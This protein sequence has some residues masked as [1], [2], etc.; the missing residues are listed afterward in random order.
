MVAMIRV[1]GWLVVAI[2]A[3]GVPLPATGALALPLVASTG[4]VVTDAGMMA[5]TD[6]E[7][8]VWVAGGQSAFDPAARLWARRGDGGEPFL[9][10]TTA[11]A[12]G[13]PAIDNGVV[14]WLENR[15][16]RECPVC[17]ASLIGKDLASGREFVVTTDVVLFANYQPSISGSLVVWTSSD[18]IWVRDIATMIDPQAV[19]T[20]SDATCY[21]RY[22]PV[23]S[24]DRVA[25]MECYEPT[26]RDPRAYPNY[27]ILTKRLGERE[28]TVVVDEPGNPVGYD[29]AGD[30]LV[31]AN[32]ISGITIV[33]LA[34]GSR[35]V[36]GHGRNPTIDGRTVFWEAPADPRDAANP[37]V[38]LRGLDLETMTSFAAIGGAD[39]NSRPDSGGDIVVWARSAQEM[40]GP[41]VPAE[42]RVASVRDLLPTAPR[43]D[44]ADPNVTWRPETGHSIGG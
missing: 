12:R 18:T 41:E 25:W 7:Y 26:V 37:R 14:V 21:F 30:R 13:W 43:P 4:A 20:V 38:D 11:N 19:A 31:Y 2:L 24:G 33:D 10:T 5:R 44:P 3:A 16:E 34:S 23:I 29:L 8:I 17:R 6:G 22:P 28:T 1:A 27:R 39:V 40:D 36:V 15:P 42:V 35:Q 32:P 9:L